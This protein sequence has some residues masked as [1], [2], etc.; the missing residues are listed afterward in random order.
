MTSIIYSINDPISNEP[1]YVGMTSIPLNE[2]LNKHC[3][4]ARRHISTAPV[5]KWIASLLETGLRPIIVPISRQISVKKEAM[6]L[7]KYF[8]QHAQAD[9]L[10]VHHF[11]NK[12][13]H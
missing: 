7:E 13:K 6:E 10:N 8:I 1:R 3:T 2:R 5:H 9:L 12:T 11:I 4:K